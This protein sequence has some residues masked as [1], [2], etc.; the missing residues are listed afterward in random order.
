MI[1]KT[2]YLQRLEEATYHVS[3]LSIKGGAWNV[4]MYCSLCPAVDGF[5]KWR[6]TSC[7]VA[8]KPSRTS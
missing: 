5:P 6:G 8:V 3:D 1:D 4:L 2:F 7:T